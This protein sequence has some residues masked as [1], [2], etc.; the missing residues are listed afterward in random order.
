M[1]TREDVIDAIS[2]VEKAGYAGELTRAAQLE[3]LVV[4]RPD[5]SR[6]LARLQS[7]FPQVFPSPGRPPA[8][9]APP[10]AVPSGTAEQDGAAIRALRQAEAALALQQTATARFDR[11]V[12][13]A[14]LH[15]HTT[16]T[17]GR[18]RLDELELQIE[19]AARGWD[20]STAAGAREFQRYLIAQLDRIIGVVQEVNDDD[21][22]KRALAAAWAALYAAQAES[23]QTTKASEGSTGAEV[24]AAPAGPGF[25]TYTGDPGGFGTDYAEPE[26]DG[27]V[28]R[29]VPATGAFP[30][31]PAIPGLAAE[32]PAGAALPGGAGLPGGFAM[33]ALTRPPH[34]A[35]SPLDVEE[36]TPEDDASTETDASSDEPQPD[37]SADD[38]AG[39]SG[40][41]P[42]E[43]VLPDGDTVT[44]TDHRLAAVIRATAGGTPVAEAFRLQGV[45]IPPPGTAVPD[46]LSPAQI[47]PGD[48]GMFTDRHALA[49]GNRKAL[50]DGQLHSVDNVAGPSFLGWE[51]PPMPVETPPSAPS[52]TRPTA[53]LRA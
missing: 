13:E 29:G 16:T 11:Q 4:P 39:P 33:P 35:A 31:V 24:A 5:Y 22:S 3:I 52:P 28:Q 1:T 10:P 37:Q 38:A 46:P 42:T 27:P 17:E 34:E 2:R 21:E 15:A 32:A 51:H 50:L 7:S 20:L 44:V 40:A 18:R 23:T 53:T 36:S 47:G 25:D 43:V 48:I 26:V 45:H 8:S 14:L 49:V 41:G 12:V 30:G 19:S 9:P 6:I